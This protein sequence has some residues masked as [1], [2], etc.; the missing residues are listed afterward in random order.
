MTTLQ[1]RD[2]S[3]TSEAGRRHAMILTWNPDKWPVLERQ[4]I[5]LTFCG[6]VFS[7]SRT[8]FRQEC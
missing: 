8:R 3:L 1:Q 6:N 5:M 7:G 4:P 2:H